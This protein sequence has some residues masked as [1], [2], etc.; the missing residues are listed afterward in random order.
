MKIEQQTMCPYQKEERNSVG[1]VADVHEDAFIMMMMYDHL[2]SLNLTKW[3]E[4]LRH[5]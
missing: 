3:D 2:L 1:H 4:T 5:F